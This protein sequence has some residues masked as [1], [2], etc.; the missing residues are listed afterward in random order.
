MQ[1]VANSAFGGWGLSTDQTW[2]ADLPQIISQYHPEIVIGT[3]SWDDELAQ[4]DPQAYLAEL[5]EALRTILTP[6][7]GVDLVVLLQFPQVGPN[8]YV[9]DPVTQAA[10]W[11]HRTPA[12]SSGTTSPARRCSFF[13]GQALYLQTDQ[14]FAPGDRYFT[15]NRTPTGAWIRARK[16]DNTHMCPYGAAELGSLVVNDLTPVLGLSPMAPG[17]ELG[18]WVHDPTTTTRPEPVPPTNLP[19]GTPA[20][21]CRGRRR[22]APNIR[23]ARPCSPPWPSTCAHR[24][25][26]GRPR[27][28]R[29]TTTGG[30]SR[31]PSSSTRSVLGPDA[32]AGL[33]EFSHVEVVFLF[34]RV[35]DDEITRGARH[36]RGRADW[37]AVGILAQR[38]KARPNRI[39]VTV[40]ELLAVDEHAPCA[41]AGSTPST[42][43]RCSTSSPTCPPSAPGGRSVSRRGSR[44]SCATTGERLSPRHRRAAAVG[45]RCGL[46]ELSRHPEEDVLAPVGRHQLHPDGQALGRSSAAAGRSPAVPSR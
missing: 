16:I 31:R 46:L 14:L 27:R 40:C 8:P 45:P 37:P 39:G 19:R 6:G 30:W 23:V 15:W 2:A 20:S 33:A 32:T 12:R 38:A 11:P 26:R 9:I 3:W 21:P 35:A 13:P 1:V 17:W 25:R 34:D 36:P 22:S 10:A 29:S 18:S 42:A 44:S 24:H 28:D 7:D 4:Q 5:T 41:S 43:P